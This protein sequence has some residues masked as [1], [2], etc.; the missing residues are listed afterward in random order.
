MRLVR[1]LRWVSRDGEVE[2]CALVSA[3][4]AAEAVVAMVGGCGWWKV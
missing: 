1:S 3:A 4:V 2:L